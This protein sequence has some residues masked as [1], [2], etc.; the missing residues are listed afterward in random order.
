M[1]RFTFADNLGY[2]TDLGVSLLPASVALLQDDLQRT[3]RELDDCANRVANALRDSG[4]AV[5][6]RVAL[7]FDNDVR[8]VEVMLGVMR[9][10]AVVV[11]V[12][13]KLPSDRIESVILDSGSTVAIATRRL[14]PVA[15]ELRSSGVVQLSVAVDSAD[16]STNTIGYDEWLAAA[17]SERLEV[18][19]GADA[20]CMQPYTS[21]STGNPKGVLV[22]H[23]GLLRNVQLMTQ[24]LMLRTDDR[25]LASTPLFHMNATVCGV[26]PC[27]MAG[28]SVAVLPTFDAIEVI[29][30]IERYRCTYTQGVPAMYKMVLGHQD[31]LKQRDLSSMRFL[32]VGSAPMPESLLNEL[33]NALPGV[34]VIEGYGLT[35]SGPVLT[36]QPRWGVR[37]QGSIGLP[38]P[39]VEVRLVGAD[40]HDVEVGE[41]G[42]LWARH[43]SNALGYHNL[44][45]ATLERFTDDGWM[46]SGDLVRADDDGF[47][48]FCGRI[49]DMLN[50]GGENVY[51][52]EVE[53]LIAQH[54]EVLDVSV[55]GAE[56]PVKG[57]VPVAFVVLAPGS[58]LTPGEIKDHFM[59]NG[60]AFAHPREVHI[61]ETMP[62]A[63]TG[64]TDRRQ[65][66]RRATPS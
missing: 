22:S 63:P 21:G 53:A 33:A 51:P 57:T 41:V 11:P 55:V 48:Y 52:A 1:N 25:V 9:L 59:Q 42:E 13:P 4:V 30:N 19:L 40:G 31:E 32:T 50:V 34:A 45:E 62:L 2:V 15:A 28:A 54:P 65:L 26:L 38:L 29:R 16:A 43:E 35:E 24:A 64:K 12:N 6:D 14:A 37:R 3:Y 27:L 46:R 66:Q 56:H 17:P 10:G 60:P 7:L 47:I 23:H 39:D 61:L 49:D 44:P 36:L 18:E 8:F 58:T 20:V 5:G